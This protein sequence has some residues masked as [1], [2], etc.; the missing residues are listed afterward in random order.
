MKKKIFNHG[1]RPS[2]LPYKCERSGSVI[3]FLTHDRGAAGSSLTG[4]TALC[5]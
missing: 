1:A 4:V 2:Y 5:L 3:E